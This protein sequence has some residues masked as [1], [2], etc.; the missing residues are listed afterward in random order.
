MAVRS[1]NR[2]L[3]QSPYLL[4]SALLLRALEQ[5]QK[6]PTNS[7]SKLVNTNLPAEAKAAVVEACG[8]HHR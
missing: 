2:V 8:S 6:P 4:L 5:R 7:L 1:R 3:L